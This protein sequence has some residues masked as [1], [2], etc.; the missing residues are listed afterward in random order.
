MHRFP[1]AL[2]VTLMLLGGLFA[3]ARP[4][5]AAPAEQFSVSGCYDF[6]GGVLFCDEL[7]GVAKENA[8]ASGN[9]TTFQHVKGCTEVFVDGVLVNRRC[10]T[11][12]YTA[13]QQDGESQVT[14]L[15]G[16]S[17][18]TFDFQGTTYNC[19]YSYNLLYVNGE[20]VHSHD[21]PVCD[22]PL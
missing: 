9:T 17:T 4:A 12:L 3:L 13:H 1:A 5:A 19:T 20:F 22:P 18:T 7:T 2:A 14:H 16:R 15:R 6:G 10:F 21:R 11:D 8:S